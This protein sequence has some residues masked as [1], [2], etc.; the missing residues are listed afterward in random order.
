MVPTFYN[1]G[2][3]SLKL[4]KL[5]QT[6]WQATAVDIPAQLDKDKIVTL[7]GPGSEFIPLQKAFSNRLQLTFENLPETDGTYAV[8]ND[9]DTLQ[10]MSFNY[11]R[12]E[13]KLEFPSLEDI[14][15]SKIYK[16]I[17][18]LFKDL[19]DSNRITDY[20]KWF[21]IFAIIF[22]LSELLIQKIFA[23]TYW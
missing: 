20:W 12:L 16:A 7:N 13:S 18:Q 19:D 5:Y 1:I 14:Q 3:L 23:W 6:I 17:P 8:R 10:H 22:A 9:L 21:V 4:P 11:P 15:Q 2:K